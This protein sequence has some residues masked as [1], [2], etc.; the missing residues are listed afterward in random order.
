[1]HKAIHI[2]VNRHMLK[3]ILVT[4]VF[5]GGLNYPQGISASRQARN[6]IPTATPIK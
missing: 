3:V 6:N 4:F 5:E 1:M 2:L